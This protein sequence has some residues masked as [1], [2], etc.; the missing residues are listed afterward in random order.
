MTTKKTGWVQYTAAE[1]KAKWKADKAAGK[2][3]LTESE[4]TARFIMD[5]SACLNQKPQPV[6]KKKPSPK[7]KPKRDVKVVD[8]NPATPE[9]QS[10]M[11]GKKKKKRAAKTAPKSEHVPIGLIGGQ[12]P[13]AFAAQ[14]MAEAASQPLP[15]NP[16]NDTTVLSTGLTAK[17][18]VFCREYITDFNATRAAEA[19]GY[20]KKTARAMG[21]ENLTKPDIQK[22]IHSLTKPRLA[23][24][25]IT[26]DRIM[27]EYASMAFV[28]LNDFLRRNEDGTLHVIDGMP[29]L[30][31]TDATP[32]QIA[33]LA[34]FETIILPAMGEDEPN[35]IKIKVKLGD[36][37]GS[38]D[39]LAKRAGLLKEHIVHSGEVTVKGDIKDLAMKMAFMLRK[40][41]TKDDKKE[42]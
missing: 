7:G 39:V 20:S 29:S 33:G 22:F 31:F 23:K 6:D 26:A 32:E 5:E 11:E 19:A 42:G 36:K 24:L 34:G 12:P 17:Q 16:Q 40:A 30:D 14:K 25:D 28:N 8:K 2:T 15:A 27:Q 3:T 9:E 21:S 13:P 37:K 38:L 4:W 1:L 18:E 10:R 35:P 41:A